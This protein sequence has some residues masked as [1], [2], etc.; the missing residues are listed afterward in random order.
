MTSMPFEPDIAKAKTLPSRWYYEPEAVALEKERIFA[1]TWQCVGA[2]SRVTNVGDWFTADIAGEPIVVVRAAVGESG[3]KAFHNVCRHRGGPIAVGDHGSA[4]MFR[5]AYHG[6][7]YGLDGALKTTP[8]FNG[9][10]CFDKKDFGLAAIPSVAVFGPFVFVKLEAGGPTL[11]ETL[12]KIPEETKRFPL[13]RMGFY[14]RLTWEL[15]CNW[16]VYVDNYLEGYHI[17]IV[18]PG[19]MREL[20]Y[21]QYRVEA[22]RWYSKQYAPIRN[23][24]TSIYRRNLEAGA[25]AEALYYWVFPN[26]MLNIYPD[27]IQINVIVPLGP[28]RTATVFD[29]YLVDPDKPEVAADFAKSLAFSEVVQEEDVTICEA[30]QKGLR[31]RSYDSGRYSVEREAG[32]HHF[33]GLYSELMRD[34]K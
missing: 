13:Q 19:L 33:H 3:L 34:P 8:E 32:V 4:K 14:K 24:E 27:N 30:V 6:W 1:R 31:S 12:G 26:L 9:V 25:N 7:I 28:D 22:E 23:K 16:K 5:C 20:D 21:Q 11:D 10:E 2:M 29:W 18:H 15:N 17:P